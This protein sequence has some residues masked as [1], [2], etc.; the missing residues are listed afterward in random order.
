MVGSSLIRETFREMFGSALADDSSLIQG[1]RQVFESYA[2]WKDSPASLSLRMEEFLF[3]ALYERLGPGMTC[4]M[5][6][7]T[8]RRVLMSDLPQLADQSLFPFFASMKRYSVN[9]EIIHAY[10][11]ESG[12]FSAMRALYLCYQDYLPS[13]EALWIEKIVRENL[14][15]SLRERWFTLPWQGNS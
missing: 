7:G 12:S 10:W 14:S 2:S 8:F 11:M 5:D 3:N 15:P 1:A 13:Q 9:Y 4:R 6:D